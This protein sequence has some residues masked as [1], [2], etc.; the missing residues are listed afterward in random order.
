MDR[1]FARFP[2]LKMEPVR[3]L[4]RIHQYLIV[5]PDKRIVIHHARAAG[6]AQSPRVS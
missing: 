3:T 5:D 6:T 4:P 1:D 2:R